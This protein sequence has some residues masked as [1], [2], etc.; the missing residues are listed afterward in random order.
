M[1]GSSIIKIRIGGP[2]SHPAAALALIYPP[3]RS[4]VGGHRGPRPHV[5]RPKGGDGGARR[6]FPREQGE[7]YAC[8]GKGGGPS[9]CSTLVRPSS[10]PL[11]GF[12]GSASDPKHRSSEQALRPRFSPCFFSYF[13]VSKVHGTI[14]TGRGIYTQV[15]NLV[16][17]TSMFEKYNCLVVC[18]AA[19]CGPRIRPGSAYN[20]IVLPFLRIV[21]VVHVSK[22]PP[23]QPP[24][25]R[26]DC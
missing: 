11:L 18:V 26:P 2:S 20:V 7:K 3:Q 10:A 6:K 22:P 17:P 16:T 21:V 23:P 15:V 14:D 9:R 4:L 25:H 12:R 8:F 5:A 13:F 24:R 19:G 1:S